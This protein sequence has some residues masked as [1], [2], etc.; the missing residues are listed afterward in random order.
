MFDLKLD[1]EVKLVFNNEVTEITG[2]NHWHLAE[3]IC[4][5]IKWG[6]KDVSFK[7]LRGFLTDGTSVTRLLHTLIPVWDNNTN[8]VAI[9][10]WLCC[11]PVVMINGVETKMRR[12]EIDRLFLEVMKFNG[13][14]KIR[15]TIMYAGIRAYVLL[16]I[17]KSGIELSEKIKMEEVIRQNIDS[18]EPECNCA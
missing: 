6:T 5:D 14:S 10:D 12:D 1:G 11:F 9:H 16:G 7:I 15:R 2:K 13:L 17:K 18:E 8:G 4:V 3:D